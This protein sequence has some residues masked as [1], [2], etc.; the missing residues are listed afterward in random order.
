MHWG[1]LQTVILQ[2]GTRELQWLHSALVSVLSSIGYDFKGFYNNA[3]EAGDIYVHSGCIWTWDCETH[4]NGL[5]LTFSSPTNYSVWVTGVLCLKFQ[6]IGDNLSFGSCV[7]LLFHMSSVVDLR[8]SSYSVSKAKLP[9]ICEFF[10]LN[11]LIW[12]CQL[13]SRAHYGVFF[14]SLDLSSLLGDAISTPEIPAYIFFPRTGSPAW[15]TTTNS[16]AGVEQLWIYLASI[17]WKSVETADPLK[18]EGNQCFT[19]HLCRCNSFAS[20]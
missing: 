18:W 19:G 16:T 20:Y 3:F 12:F 4:Q 15:S 9:C 5:M 13:S 2:S 6:G 17:L 1:G 8:L 14:C 11:Q 10:S 7:Q